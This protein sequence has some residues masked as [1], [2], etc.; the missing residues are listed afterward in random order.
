MS[1]LFHISLECTFCPKDKCHQGS[2]IIE[3]GEITI[4]LYSGFRFFLR[5]L[6]SAGT[7]CKLQEGGQK[8][9]DGNTSLLEH[10]N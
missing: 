9:R 8:N 5:L 10:S 2:V 1:F 3:K 7:L 4:G 6:Y